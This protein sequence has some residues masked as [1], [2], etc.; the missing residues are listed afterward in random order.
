MR[1]FPKTMY[2][3][4][5]ENEINTHTSGG[6]WYS[7]VSHRKEAGGPKKRFQRCCCSRM[8]S[9]TFEFQ[10]GFGCYFGNAFYF[11]DTCSAWFLKLLITFLKP[12]DVARRERLSKGRDRD[13]SFALPDDVSKD[14]QLKDTK[15]DSD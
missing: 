13:R 6:S 15:N 5:C 2:L 7:G 10:S 8:F 9:S 4:G 3:G 12:N 11:D 1:Y 14:D